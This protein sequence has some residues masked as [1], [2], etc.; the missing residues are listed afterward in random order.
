MCHNNNNGLGM[1]A[2]WNRIRQKRRAPDFLSIFLS[3]MSLYSFRP[4][5]CHSCVPDLAQTPSTC[6]LRRN[7]ENFLY[8][9]YLLAL[10]E[11]IFVRVCFVARLRVTTASCH[12][13]F[14]ISIRQSLFFSLY[15]SNLQLYRS[16][17]CHGIEKGYVF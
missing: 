15:E 16:S 7:G 9:L 4:S 14:S 3:R 13:I 8:P 6:Q 12:W 1:A 11:F 10:L 2:N 17:F 5:V